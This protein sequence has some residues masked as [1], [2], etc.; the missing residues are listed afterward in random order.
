ME[1]KQPED[2]LVA[3][4]RRAATA[5]ET[6]S[7]VFSV[8]IVEALELQQLRALV[9]VAFGDHATHGMSVA[10]P[11]CTAERDLRKLARGLKA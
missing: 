4:Y 8:A 1:L 6:I 11:A 10:C 2:A 3:R 5:M 7:E 9:V